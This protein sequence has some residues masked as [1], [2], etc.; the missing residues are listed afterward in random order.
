MLHTG[1]GCVFR[2]DN[3]YLNCSSE[4]VHI[5]WAQ[6][7][8]RRRDPGN[9]A[10]PANAYYDSESQQIDPWSELAKAAVDSLSV[11]TA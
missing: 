3:A 2:S 5:H 8:P 9:R 6:C 4:H 10:M 1:A 7:L 11:H